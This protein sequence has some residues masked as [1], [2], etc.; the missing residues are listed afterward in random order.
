MFGRFSIIVLKADI[1]IL[2][3]IFITSSAAVENLPESERQ[4]VR[5]KWKGSPGTHTSCAEKIH[6]MLAVFMHLVSALTSLTPCLFPQSSINISYCNTLHSVRCKA[7]KEL[8]T[9]HIY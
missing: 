1:A 5:R 3:L 8:Y 9:I 4:D 7:L 6:W 2:I